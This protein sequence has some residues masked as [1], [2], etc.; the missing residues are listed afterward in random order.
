[1]SLTP[2]QLQELQTIV[3]DLGEEFPHNADA[4][5]NA[6]IRI[7]TGGLGP[8]SGSGGQPAFDAA[9]ADIK[10][11]QE[12]VQRYQQR[13]GSLNSGFDVAVLQVVPATSTFPSG[14]VGEILYLATAPNS[15]IATDQIVITPLG[16][17][18]V[19][20]DEVGTTVF[21]TVPAASGGIEINNLSTGAGFERVLTTADLT[22]M[23]GQ[24]DTVVGGT[25]ISVNA[26]DPVNPIVNLDAAI[27]GVSVDGVTLNA[28][29]AATNYLDE[30][31]SYSVPVGAGGGGAA[32]S[33]TWT[34][35]AT[36]VGDPGPDEFRT[37]TGNL[38]SVTAMYFSDTDV[39]SLDIQNILSTMS[40][41]A[42]F[43]MRKVD[44]NSQ[45][46]VYSITGITDNAGWYQFN[47]DYQ[48]GNG[49]TTSLT[50]GDEVTFEFFTSG[51]VEPGTNLG[52]NSDEIAYWNPSS[53][54]WEGSG[55]LI[56]VNVQTPPLGGRLQLGTTSGYSTTSPQ[57]MR[58]LGAADT[59]MD[60]VFGTDANNGFLQGYLRVAGEMHFG[61]RIASVNTVLL[62]FDLSANVLIEAAAAF[63]IGEQGAAAA[64]LAAYGQLW[65]N[66]ADDSLNYQT[67]AGVN[68]DLT[69][70]AGSPFT[71]PLI[72]LGDINTA[73]P[74]TTEAVTG[75]VE[76]W[77]LSET[78]KLASFGFNA[79]DQLEMINEMQGAA[80]DTNTLHFGFGRSTN[81]S[82]EGMTLSSEASLILTSNSTATG[83]N[84]PNDD[85]II[86]MV[87]RTRIQTFLE[88]GVYGATDSLQLRNL[89]TGQP[90]VL[91][92]RF[93][94]LV[95]NVAPML[96][97]NPHGNIAEPYDSQI[98][99]VIQ[100]Y[101]EQ[102]VAAFPASR[103]MPV[104][105]GV[106]QINT[107]GAGT[108]ERVLTL[109]D[110]APVDSVFTRTGA[111]VGVASDYATV[112]I[113]VN[114]SVRIDF[115]TGFDFQMQF[116][117]SNM[118]FVGPGGG[119]IAI[120][121]GIDQLRTTGALGINEASAPDGNVAG[122]GQVWVENTVPNRLMFTDDTDSNHVVAISGGTV[123]ENVS[124][125]SSFNFNTAN[126][127][128]D[129]WIGH[130]FDGGNNT[131]TLEDSGSQVN[132]PLYTTINIIAPGSGNQTVVEGSGT[133]LFD[134]QGNDTIGGVV[135]SQG[136]VSITRQSSTNYI[137]W[138]SGWT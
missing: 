16:P 9:V 47:V 8:T 132:W 70:P 127:Y 126:N 53:N 75:N 101:G 83:G 119:S 49:D 66:S 62:T 84:A 5:W 77:D 89:M 98:G 63:R 85:Q 105:S 91:E 52:G 106:F 79:D 104:A 123:G 23:G 2:T 19:Q 44:D 27:T 121:S 61:A 94:S 95:A 116:D 109:S 51:Y 92:G 81:S 29:G 20:M 118:S 86:S 135:V 36:P 138:G 37:S 7:Q 13:E 134:D 76:I 48:F 64:D 110:A 120:F 125:N 59:V 78:D 24:V 117:G 68:F 82:I 130:Y 124:V 1:M 6:A 32:G 128:A 133:T 71:Q 100:Y 10:L 34:F 39:D 54:M 93:G 90:T 31:G 115:G 111:V 108:W 97:A 67:E 88:L 3:L 103:T 42:Y 80:A 17:N 107:D 122:I 35:D 21:R 12:D 33:I 60:Y 22:V 129:N 15:Y 4:L 72:V 58:P 41:G 112:G 114:D 18:S 46:R 113:T 25:N 30:S 137:I 99:G 74:P 136:V 87:N 131:I 55:T 26:G 38:T 50:V 14:N 28:V 73:T 65:V 56:T 45:F 43:V 96:I 102:F 69:A 57:I 40:I 11:C